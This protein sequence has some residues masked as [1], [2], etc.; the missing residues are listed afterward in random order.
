MP[1]TMN[2]HLP[3]LRMR[4]VLRVR[5]GWS[6]RQAARYVGVQPSTV[7][8]WMRRAPTDGR[9]V[10]PTQSSRP[11]A[12]PRQLRP[13]IVDAI[14]RTRRAHGRCAEV[15]HAELA[16]QS[17][18]V[19]LSSVK[20]TLARRGLLQCRSPWQRWHAPEPRPRAEKPGNLVEMDTI[21]IG[22][23]GP[24]RLYVYTL[25]DVCSRWAYAQVARRITT[26]QSL[27]F[28]HAAQRVAPFRFR[29]VQ[30]DHGTEFAT[31]FTER[32]G[33]RGVGHRHARVRQPN[34]NGHLE[35]FNRTLK[36]EGLR[37]VPANARRYRQAI[38]AYLPYYNGERLHLGLQ[39][40]TPL[41]VL[42]SY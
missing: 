23:T 32:L 15:V 9:R 29:V 13:L 4:T 17:I 40:H 31:T 24:C 2:P 3:K 22:P 28:V 5:Q 19:S 38:A 21:H 42:R 16:Q 7:L 14:V 34:D 30:T 1:Y 35:R 8:R 25:L 26:H 33:V 20:R 36:E 18:V 39:L 37:N 6:I 27:R 41:Q 11:R 12:H 10:I